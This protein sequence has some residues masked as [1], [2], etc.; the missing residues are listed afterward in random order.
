[1]LNELT[2]DKFPNQVLL[3]VERSPNPWCLGYLYDLDVA[4]MHQSMQLNLIHTDVWSH[5]IVVCKHC[6]NCAAPY[7]TSQ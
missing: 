7:S 4:K 6:V 3:N 5:C 2:Y 1:M